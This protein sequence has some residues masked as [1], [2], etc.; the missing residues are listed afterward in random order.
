MNWLQS[1]NPEIRAFRERMI[2]QGLKSPE[3]EQSSH[4]AWS[5]DD[6]IETVVESVQKSRISDT[7]FYHLRFDHFFPDELYAAMLQAMPVSTDYRALFDRHNGRNSSDGAPSFTS[8]FRLAV[9]AESNTSSVRAQQR[10][11]VRSR[12]R[13]LAFRRS[14]RPGRENAR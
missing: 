6:L 2:S 3:R 8:G 9:K 5:V 7:P 11:C 4:R 10:L 12:E 1:S 13:Y 14:G